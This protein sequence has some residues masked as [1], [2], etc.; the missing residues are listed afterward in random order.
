MVGCGSWSTGSSRSPE[1]ILFEE[2]PEP[3]TCC[4][5]NCWNEPMEGLTSIPICGP[6]ANGV[7]RE[8]KRPWMRDAEAARHREM[9]ERYKALGPGYREALLAERRRND[10]EHVQVYYVLLSPG[11]VKIGYTKFI[12]NRM[13]SFRAS[14]SAL[15]ATEPGGREVEKRRHAQFAQ[16]RIGRR[17]DFRL[18]PRLQS[19]IESMRVKHDTW[20]T[21]QYRNDELATIPRGVA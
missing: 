15:L 18:T 17:E 8:M 12:L 21:R 9:E 1:D 3:A 4:A 2:D 7:V 16:E 14:L 19:H 5:P 6:H 20:L 11:I 10:L 13:A